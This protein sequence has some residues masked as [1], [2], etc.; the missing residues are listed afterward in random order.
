MLAPVHDPAD[1]GTGF[2]RDLDQVEIE[3]GG[4]LFCLF[5]GDD[6]ELV[7][8]GID[9]TDGAEMDLV[10]ETKSL[11]CDSFPSFSRRARLATRKGATGSGFRGPGTGP[12]RWANAPRK[13]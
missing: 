8:I 9:E 12:L 4:F 2:S 6:P 11:L 10:V 3:L 7:S 13:M 5:K 1:D